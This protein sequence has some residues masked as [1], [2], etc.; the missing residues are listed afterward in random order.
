MGTH[1]VPARQSRKIPYLK[2]SP[3]RSTS[4]EQLGTRIRENPREIRDLLPLRKVRNGTGERFW[5]FL[6][7]R[8]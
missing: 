2:P 1:T 4:F 8:G 3:Q 6:K 7:P 5:G